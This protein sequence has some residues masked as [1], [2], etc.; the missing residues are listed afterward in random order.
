MKA[1]RDERIT[2]II[3]TYNRCEIL[4][5]CLERLEAQSYRDFHVLVV[6]DGSTDRTEEVLL[7]ARS[8]LRLQWLTQKNAGPARGRN[9]AL[10]QVRTRL[11]ILI[12]DDILAGREFVERHLDLHTNRPEEAV[13]GLGWTRWDGEWQRLTPFMHWLENVQFDYANLLAG[14][15]PTWQH[16]YT[17]NLSFKTSLLLKFPFDER[18]RKAAYEDIELGYRL[19]QANELE[20]VFLKEAA[21]THVHPMTL[22]D[23]ARRMHSVGYSEHQL[24]EYWPATR[25]LPPPRWK[26]AIVHGLADRPRV[27]QVLTKMTGAAWGERRPNKAI[28]AL[29][30]AHHRRGYLDYSIKRNA[31]VDH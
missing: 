25:P 24:N 31:A 2:I 21:A 11:C 1:T 6:N 22:A 27:L 4:R 5:V 18:F 17:S 3:P 28:A 16:F 19:A 8:R 29:L 7:D 9:Q 20:L 13:V 30:L 10:A 23:A 14:T 26:Q 12:G 15:A